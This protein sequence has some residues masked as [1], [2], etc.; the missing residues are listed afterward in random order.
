MEINLKKCALQWTD[1]KNVLYKNDINIMDINIDI[2]LS[3]D[4]YFSYIVY[5]YFQNSTTGST[6]VFVLKLA[7]IK[8][9]IQLRI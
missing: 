1:I 3:K 6:L 7:F 8:D 9:V 4:T 5:T 2:L